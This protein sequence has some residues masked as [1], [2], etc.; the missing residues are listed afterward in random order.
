VA[1]AEGIGRAGIERRG[2]VGDA[3]LAER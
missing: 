2:I 3:A 1:A